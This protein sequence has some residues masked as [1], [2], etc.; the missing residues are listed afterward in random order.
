LKYHA[1]YDGNDTVILNDNL[2]GSS[3]KNAVIS[4]CAPLQ[5]SNQAHTSHAR[6]SSSKKPSKPAESVFQKS[7]QANSSLSRTPSKLAE[8]VFQH[9]S[10][11]NSGPTKTPLK[12]VVSVFQESSQA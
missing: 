1:G 5:Q 3:S 10:Q 4:A 9:S 12:P 8:S 6:P 11:T 7:S 2:P